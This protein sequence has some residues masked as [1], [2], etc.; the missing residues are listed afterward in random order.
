MHYNGFRGK[1]NIF[2]RRYKLGKELIKAMYGRVGLLKAYC[3]RCKGTYFVIDGVYQCCDKKTIRIYTKVKTKRYSEGE[4]KRTKIKM[5][6]K[7]EIVE[8]QKN[9]CI[10]C[11]CNLDGFI[12]FE[13]NNAYR[14]VKIHFDHFI[15]WNYSRDNNKNNLVA[16]CQICNLLKSDKYF[17]DLS[18]AKEYILEERKKRNYRNYL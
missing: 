17:Q 6:T 12:W 7:K 5:T 13:K 9:K 8:K 16:S 3:D 15:S 2:K 1:V 18:L 14:K 4:S 10:Y 11:N